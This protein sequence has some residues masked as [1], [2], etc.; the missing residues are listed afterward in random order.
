MT[1]CDMGLGVR[2]DG[3]WTFVGLSLED[4]YS[5]TV[6]VVVGTTKAVN[7]GL[8]ST[9]LPVQTVPIGCGFKN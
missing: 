8:G 2:C 3:G 1:R 4:H 7:G 5:S 9:T 6:V